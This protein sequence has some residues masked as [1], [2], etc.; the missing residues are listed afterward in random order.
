MSKMRL[1][2]LCL[3][4]I[5]SY[6]LPGYAQKTK[7]TKLN[8]FLTIKCA[9]DDSGNLSGAGELRL[10]V[11]GKGN[12]ESISE[13]FYFDDVKKV[14]DPK[15]GDCLDLTNARFSIESV[16]PRYISAT[17]G[18]FS[19]KGCN[20]RVKLKQTNVN[21]HDYLFLI[22][23]GGTLQ[24]TSNG[25]IPENRRDDFSSKII[26][27]FSIYV[28]I[29]PS[30]MHRLLFEDGAAIT[31]NKVDISEAEDDRGYKLG[32][33]NIINDIFGTYQVYQG[34][35][36]DAS[37]KSLTK[38][39]WQAEDGTMIRE[40]GK[41][42]E[43]TVY[44]KSGGWVSHGYFSIDGETI[45]KNSSSIDSYDLVD[46]E[47]KPLFKKVNGRKFLGF[48]GIQKDG[49]EV[50]Y[51]DFLKNFESCIVVPKRGQWLAENSFDE[52]LAVVD[53]FEEMSV[54]EYEN[55]EQKA[56]EAA[57]KAIYDEIRDFVGTWTNTDNAKDG[58]Y[59]KNYTVTV[60]PDGTAVR[61]CKGYY[62]YIGIAPL[63]GA[64]LVYEYNWTSE[65]PRLPFFDRKENSISVVSSYHDAHFKYTGTRTINGAQKKSMTKD[66]VMDVELLKT[67]EWDILTYNNGVLKDNRGRV[68]RKSGAR[69]TK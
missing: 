5:G 63:T 42:D 47:G 37:S 17:D 50:S 10:Y 14:N 36:A 67:P 66:D 13:T 30:S 40:K 29:E 6:A 62:K 48:W 43:L 51:K 24:K 1:L 46:N 12:T 25:R 39:L 7:K 65:S 55:R 11:L 56:K 49:K 4:L 38:G 54:K 31:T 57:A 3:L 68:F 41:F 64:K 34:Y 21:G 59:R 23:D 61:K 69:A 18:T 32:G 16:D 22:A 53:N 52:I 20:T 27:P 58:S 35:T 19:F 8:Q 28:S 2:L 33:T 9:V 15:L 44:R 45:F 26:S 60:Y